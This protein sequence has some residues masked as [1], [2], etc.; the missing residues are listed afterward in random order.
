[1]ASAKKV[2]LKSLM[3]SKSFDKDNYARR[4]LEKTADVVDSNAD[5]LDAVEAKVNP[6]IAETNLWA[7]CNWVNTDDL[8]GDKVKIT[9][10]GVEGSANATFTKVNA[11]HQTF[12]HAK[13]IAFVVKYVDDEGAPRTAEAITTFHIY[14]ADTNDNLQYLTTQNNKSCSEIVL[15]MAKNTDGIL[16]TTFIQKT[17]NIGA[18]R[19]LNISAFNYDANG[20]EYR[21][22]FG[23]AKAKQDVTEDPDINAFSIEST[24]TNIRGK[25]NVYIYAVFSE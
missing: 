14:G 24:N 11:E 5:K 13:A 12:A 10:A 22:Y 19:G 9:Q 17:G 21:L 23:T 7:V 2:N 25:I 8:N 20:E 3:R 15:N 1:M 6:T 16:Q 18:A 4:V